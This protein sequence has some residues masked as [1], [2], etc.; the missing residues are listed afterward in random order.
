MGRGTRPCPQGACSLL[1]ADGK[2]KRNGPGEDRDIKRSDVR[3][4]RLK[5]K[6]GGPGGAEPQSRASLGQGVGRRG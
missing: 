1:G 5:D 4:R 3:L 6:K 2:V